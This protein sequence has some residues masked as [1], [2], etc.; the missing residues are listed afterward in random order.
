MS[1]FCKPELEGVIADMDILLK[2]FEQERATPEPGRDGS[3]SPPGT[4]SPAWSD[5]AASSSVPGTRFSAPG[6]SYSDSL[7][8][9]PPEPSTVAAGTPVPSHITR[10]FADGQLTDDIFRHI[11][12][13]GEPIVV[14]GLL[15]KFHVHWSP[16]YFIS[17]YGSQS[18]LI[19]E[20]QSDQ[21]R[22]VTVGEFFSWFGKYEGRRDC[23]KLKVRR[24]D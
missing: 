1:R 13:R 8:G 16:E 17:K 22:R 7:G 14:T 15:P 21:N 24:R 19:L 18:C 10:H 2:E 23:W 4:A 20:C 5:A 12:A 11:W 3:L 6:P 9:V